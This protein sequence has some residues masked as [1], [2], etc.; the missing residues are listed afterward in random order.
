MTR[1]LAIVVEEQLVL[2]LTFVHS[3]HALLDQPEMPEL[4][5]RPCNAL[6]TRIVILVNR[7][8]KTRVSTFVGW[9]ESVV[10]TP[11]VQQ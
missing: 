6:K 11:N 3:A 5:A 8:L 2:Y 9:M 7:V 4:N 1:A 10:T